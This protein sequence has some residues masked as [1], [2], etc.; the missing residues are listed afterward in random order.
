VE[1]ESKRKVFGV[2]KSQ[3][4]NERSSFISHWR[5]LGDY[6][7]PRR[8]RFFVSDTNRGE[9]RNQK[10]I[11]STATLAARTLRSGMMAGVTS[12]ARPW[13]RL[14]TPDPDLAEFGAVKE[15]LHNV[16]QRMT[17]VFLRSNL[18][19]ALPTVYGDMGTFGT[20]AMSV[21]EDF[22]DVIRCYPFP[23]GSYMIA[24][25][26][27]LAVN[28]FFREFRMTV[29]QL[30]QKFGKKNGAGEIDW[31]NFSEMVKS[32]Y[33]NNQREAWIDVCHVVLPNDDYNPDKID[34]KY[35][36]FVSCY[37]EAGTS[38]ATSGNYLRN[39]DNRYLR[40]SGYDYFP[41]LCPRWEVKREIVVSAFSEV[42]DT[43][44][45]LFFARGGK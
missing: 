39:D 25:D 31:S 13:F 41:F 40:E 24:N 7:L 16:T 9:R 45:S 19:N 8:P 20:A 35:K 32:A 26:D 42:A 37:Y 30:V 28:V 15:W 4:E 36:K 3:L 22:H 44:I 1:S 43:T 27:R 21:E 34:A 14:T 17:T 29:R 10:I 5:D 6:I 2:L 33:M 12:P 11:D 23:V 18:Y 38:N